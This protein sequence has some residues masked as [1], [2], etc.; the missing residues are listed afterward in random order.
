MQLLERTTR[1][2]T[3]TTA[4]EALLQDARTALD[5]VSAAARRARHAGEPTP[6]LR[7]TL[8]AD[9][10]AGLL[11]QIL[12][13]YAQEEASL[14]VKLVLGRVGEQAQTVRDGR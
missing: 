5:A 11:P 4:G 6:M 1:R 3:L 7:L 2:V 10:D 13:A 9:M 14:P 8:K 12:D